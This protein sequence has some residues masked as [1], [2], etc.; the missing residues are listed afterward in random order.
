MK[1]NFTEALAAAV[2]V[3][4]MAGILVVLV[5]LSIKAVEAVQHWAFTAAMVVVWV[6][7]LLLL[8]AWSISA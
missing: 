4:V 6:A 3:L 1:L 2:A 5:V 7:G 8:M